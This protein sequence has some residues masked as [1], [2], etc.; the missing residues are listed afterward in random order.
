[1]GNPHSSIF[2][3]ALTNVIGNSA[4]VVTWYDN[5]VGFS[6]RVVDLASYVASKM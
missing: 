4:K 1:M 3:P 5:E 6:N 2:D